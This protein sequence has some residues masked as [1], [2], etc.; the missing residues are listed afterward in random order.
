MD[1]ETADT[2][3][4]G[5]ELLTRSARETVLQAG[6][7]APELWRV[8]PA[9]LLYDGGC[10]IASNDREL[11]ERVRGSEAGTL[12]AQPAF[13]SARELVDREALVFGVVDL[14]RFGAGLRTAGKP[15]DFGQ[16]LVM[17]AFAHLVPR[18]PWAALGVD[19]GRR[20]DA[21]ELTAEVYVPASRE[22]RAGPVGEALCG[23]LDPLP[24][25]LPDRLVALVRMRRDFA[26]MWSNR[27]ALVAE[28]GI[29]DLVRFETNFA[30]LT[31]GLSWVE[32][33]LPNLGGELTLIATH[34][35]F[36]QGE[37]APAVRYPRAALLWPVRRSGDL[38]LRLRI[39]FQTAIGIVNAQQAQQGGKPFLLAPEEYRGTLIQ[40][41]RFLP[42]SEGEMQDRRHLPP[43]YN[44]A[45]AAAIVGEHLVL[46]TSPTIVRALVDGAGRT[47]PA[48]STVNA[49]VWV[50]PGEA[51]AL[52][53]VNRE[54]LVAKVM[55]DEGLDR[56]GACERIDLILDLARHVTDLE[57]TAC[58]LDEA[59]GL[60]LRAGLGRPAE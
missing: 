16:A 59:I 41:A 22:D 36:P 18:A 32:E 43:R 14:R 15:K 7:A 24:F 45:P 33:L 48:P 4:T 23:T 28:R 55:L 47:T 38:A 2:I 52:L 9:L 57:L 35:E 58:E 10:L 60:C 54:P 21:W 6:E 25:A 40:C 17:G 19:L 46:A 53:R 20:G 31:G 56:T 1:E 12:S 29:P 49:G 5:L 44:V 30:N 39:A 3:V 8:G 26:A 51:L 27:D 37:P 11:A 50:E 42:P 34:P 13:R